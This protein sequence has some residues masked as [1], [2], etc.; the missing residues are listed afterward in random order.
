MRA[1]SGAPG[2]DK[3]RVRRSKRLEIGP[4]TAASNVSA[5]Q[6]YTICPKLIM[7]NVIPFLDYAEPGLSSF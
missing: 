1:G 7:L 2:P 5:S 4:A 6:M 3:F